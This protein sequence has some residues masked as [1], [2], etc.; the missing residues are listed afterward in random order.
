VATLFFGFMATV[1]CLIPDGLNRPR[2][3]L[4]CAG[5]PAAWPVGFAGAEGRAAGPRC[6]QL[7]D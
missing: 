2:R 3:R 5:V 4:L 1:A 7:T 6:G